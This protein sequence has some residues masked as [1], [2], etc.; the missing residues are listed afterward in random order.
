MK[1][2]D[3]YALNLD[4]NTIFAAQF[5]NNN[6]E[7]MI[8]KIFNVILTGMLLCSIS[9]CSNSE[10]MNPSE[11][12]EDVKEVSSTEVFE[13]EDPTI[14]ESNASETEVATTNASSNSAEGKVRKINTET[15]IAEIFDYKSN[16]TKWVYKGS[17]P[18]I[19]DFYATWCG[20]CKRVAPIMDE[21]AEKYKG[22]VNFYK[23]DTDEEKE[24]S[25]SVFGIRSIPSILYIPV[26]GQPMMSTGLSAKDEYIRQIETNLLKK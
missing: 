8:K 4:K 20:P 24:L 25:G 7:I 26:D 19:I 10:V 21:L 3:I 22:Q 16:P 14:M 11:S 18:A 15:F 17:K 5:R 13:E 23:I 9:S 6:I 1:N 12:N 2:S